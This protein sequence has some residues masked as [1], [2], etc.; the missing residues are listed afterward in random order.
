MHE[1]YRFQCDCTH[2][3]SRCSDVRCILN[4]STICINNF[5]QI[6]QS[7]VKSINAVVNA[8][9]KTCREHMRAAITMSFY[10]VSPNTAEMHG[11]FKLYFIP[12]YLINL[13]LTKLSSPLCPFLHLCMQ[14]LQSLKSQRCNER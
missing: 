12:H 8:Y 4:G 7:C 9:T 10:T 2:L 13:I 5:N 11:V 1:S 3:F 6:E 14:K